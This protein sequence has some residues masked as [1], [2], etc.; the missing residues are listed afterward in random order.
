VKYTNEAQIKS[1]SWIIFLQHNSY[2]DMTA[3]NSKDPNNA[4]NTE[5]AS[6]KE[7]LLPL[8]EC[9]DFDQLVKE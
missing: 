7:R 4:G 3:E 1:N 5:T 8:V 6:S 2:T 9:N